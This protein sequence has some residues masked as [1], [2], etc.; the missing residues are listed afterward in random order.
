MPADSSLDS[1]GRPPGAAA[2]A[3]WRLPDHLPALDGLRAIAVLVVLAHNLSLVSGGQGFFVHE[4][5]SMLHRGWMGVQLFFV[6]SG[7]LITRILLDAQT[8]PGYFSTFYARRALRI[9]PLYYAVLIVLFVLVPAF[10]PLPSS[11]A[12]DGPLHRQAWLWGY[13]SNWSGPRGLG[14]GSPPVFHFWSLAVEEQFYLL[15][16]LIVFRTSP[17]RLMTIC[18]AVVGISI[19]CRSLYLAIGVQPLA[20]Y[21]STLS[22]MDALALGGLVAAWLRSPSA[23]MP[24]RA[25]VTR[26]LWIAAAIAAGGWI[27]TH[28]FPRFTV[29]EE[30]IGFTL[31]AAACAALLAASVLAAATPSAQGG[32]YRLLAARALRPTAKYSYAMYVLHAPLH[33][34]IG[35]PTLRRLIGSIEPRVGP[36]MAYMGVV[37]LVSFGAAWLSYRLIE[38]P[39]LRLRRHLA[40]PVAPQ[41]ATV[42]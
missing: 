21:T 12:E 14:G 28:G 27:V 39:F 22:R 10:G 33:V 8:S 2:P 17:R 26:L 42:S 30:S 1:P 6:L 20:I 7:F 34:L 25:T 24:D 5:E 29:V 16:P 15:W 40:R 13:L 4:L 32:W 9:F 31:V 18:I 41:A 35:L 3:P 11:Y 37:M 38:Q 23:P 19:A 36:A